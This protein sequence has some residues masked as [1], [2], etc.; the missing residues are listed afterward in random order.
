MSFSL[1]QVFAAV[2]LR[3]AAILNLE[4]F[5]FRRVWTEGVLGYNALQVHLTHALKQAAHRIVR[6]FVVEC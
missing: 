2:H 3:V 5:G 4:P 1:E 6:D